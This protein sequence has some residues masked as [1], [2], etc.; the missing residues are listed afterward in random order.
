MQRGP[1]SPFLFTVIADVLSR[2]MLR[3]EETSLLEGFLLR[4]K[5]RVTN[6][7]FTNDI[8]FFTKASMEGLLSNPQVGPI[9][10]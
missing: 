2:L 3:V 10:I 1:L 5:T 7:Q 4:S 9:S 6:L 8:I